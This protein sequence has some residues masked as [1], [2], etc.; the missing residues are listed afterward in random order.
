MSVLS[1]DLSPILSG[2][3]PG[4]KDGKLEGVLDPVIFVKDRIVTRGRLDGK[5]FGGVIS[6]TA[7]EAE[8]IFSSAPM[9]KLSAD[10]SSIDLGKLTGDTPFGRIEGV[11]NG[12]IRNLEIAGIQ[13]QSFD[14]LLETAEGSRGGEKISLR[15]V[16]NISRIGAGQS[17]FVGFAGVLTSFFETLSY[18]KI[19][20]RATLSNDYFTVNG[21]IDEDG[22]EYIMKRGGLSG[23][24][25]V[26][27]NPDNRIRFKDMVNRIKRVLDEDR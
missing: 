18:R 3:W 26:N 23:V 24:N 19:G 25:I 8:R 20:V 11:L 22:T 16:E 27:R 1:E 21:T 2:I 10:F 5:I 13:P 15:A 14:M 9:V 17:P 4:E 12:Y 7:L 6:I